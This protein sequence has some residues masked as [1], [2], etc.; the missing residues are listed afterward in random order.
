MI[1]LVKRVLIIGSAGAGKSTLA[2]ELGKL[3]SLPVV[4]LDS[5]Y[6][7]PGWLEMPRSE[8]KSRVAELIAID[9]W[10]MDGNYSNTMAERIEASDTVILLNFSR[11]R[12]L[13]RVFKRAVYYRGT[14]RP[15]MNAGCREQLPDLAFMKWIWNYP[16]RSLPKVLGLL[17]QCGSEKQIVILEGPEAVRNF[18]NWLIT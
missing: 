4:H 3:T 6:W 12:C 2:V 10:I 17:R 14:T 8:W 15:D 9:R 11:A 7:Q 13:Y 1:P 18:T 5:L 16:K